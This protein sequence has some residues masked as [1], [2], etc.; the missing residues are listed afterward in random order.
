MSKTTSFNLGKH[1]EGFLAAQVE[2]GLYDNK[3]EVI[4]AALRDMEERQRREVT[5]EM[6]RLSV[7]DIDAGRT[8]PAKQALREAAGSIGLNLDR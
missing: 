4:R 7:A 5:L 1:F 6:M 3:S 2:A 8:K